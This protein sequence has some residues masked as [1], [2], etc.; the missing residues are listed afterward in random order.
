MCC[1][2]RCGLASRR[3]STAWR[4][5]GFRNRGSLHA[6]SLYASGVRTRHLILVAAPALAYFLGCGPSGAVV[7]PAAPVRA[8]QAHS[9]EAERRAQQARLAID[10]FMLRQD[11]WREE[12]GAYRGAGDFPGGGTGWSAFAPSDFPSIDEP[13]VPWPGGSPALNELGFEPDG[14]VTYR[15]RFAAGPPGTSPPEGAG[16]EVASSDFWH[17]VEVE[18]AFGPNGEPMRLVGAPALASPVMLP[19]TR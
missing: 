18:G 1:G 10:A 15:L 16:V 3:T 11:A 7:P 8:E 9:A 2:G 17:I 5:H 4:D 19:A 14:P 12:F 6:T 13:G